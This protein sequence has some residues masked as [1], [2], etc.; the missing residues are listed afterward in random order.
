MPGTLPTGVADVLIRPTISVQNAILDENGPYTAGSHTITDFLTTTAHGLLPAGTWPIGGTYGVVVS[1]NGAI[2]ITWGY[3]QG[4]DSGGPVG[5]EGWRYYNRFAQ[6]VSMHQDLGGAFITIQVEDVH[7]I[8][9]WIPLIWI[10]LGGDRLGLH[11]SPDIAIDLYFM[12]L[13]A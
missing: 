2:P 9:Q 6:V 10:P 11:V 1:V 3:S 12:C 7:Y 13:L 8:Q 4:Y 5:F